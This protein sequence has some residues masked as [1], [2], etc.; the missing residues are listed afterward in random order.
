MSCHVQFSN[1][2]IELINITWIFNNNGV[3]SS[4]D[5]SVS[6]KPANGY[7]TLRKRLKLALILSSFWKISNKLVNEENQCLF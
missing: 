1:R 6:L 5:S 2:E 7:Q 4:V 3:T